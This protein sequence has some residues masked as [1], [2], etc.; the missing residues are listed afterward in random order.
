MIFTSIGTKIIELTTELTQKVERI[1][2]LEY[3]NRNISKY[4]K[5]VVSKVNELKDKIADFEVKI[6]ALEQARRN[7][8]NL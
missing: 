1:N 3:E 6:E 8:G 4:N 7:L 5:D 2:L